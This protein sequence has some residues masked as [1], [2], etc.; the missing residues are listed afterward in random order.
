[1][2]FYTRNAGGNI[3]TFDFYEME[4]NKESS[5]C[6]CQKTCGDTVEDNSW[7]EQKLEQERLRVSST[8]NFPT[9]KTFEHKLS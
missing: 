9:K 4:K 5:G 7:L 8:L 6:R 2:S 3:T 1:M